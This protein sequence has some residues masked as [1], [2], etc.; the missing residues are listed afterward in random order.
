MPNAASAFWLNIAKH[1]PAAVNALRLLIF[2]SDMSDEPPVW[3]GLCA[4][5]MEAHPDER[6][7]SVDG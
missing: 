1:T 4:S 7:D 3:N 2:D 5:A 6:G